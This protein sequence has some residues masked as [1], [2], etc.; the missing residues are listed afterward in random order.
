MTNRSPKYYKRKLEQSQIK[1]MT[2]DI[3]LQPGDIVFVKN[4]N[5]YLTHTSIINIERYVDET[6]IN[7]P[8]TRIKLKKDTIQKINWQIILSK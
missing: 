7:T 5:E 1:V 2:K 4:S 8:E 3:W 6:Y